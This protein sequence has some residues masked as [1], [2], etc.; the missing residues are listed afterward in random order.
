MELN[1]ESL[2]RIIQEALAR[3]KDKEFGCAKY[4]ST[5]QGIVV[6]FYDGPLNAPTPVEPEEKRRNEDAYDSPSISLNPLS[7]VFGGF[8]GFGGGSSGGG[9]ASGGW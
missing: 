1:E 7:G 3:Y 5:D 6:Q 2:T 4:V 8:G 9:G